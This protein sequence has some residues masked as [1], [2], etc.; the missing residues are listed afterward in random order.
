MLM[1]LLCAEVWQANDGHG[2]GTSAN[3]A[4]QQR[5]L[6]DQHVRNGTT[7]LQHGLDDLYLLLRSLRPQQDL[8]H[9][10]LAMSSDKYD[11][12]QSLR[13]QRGERRSYRV[14]DMHKGTEQGG[15]FFRYLQE[16]A[17]QVFDPEVLGVM[18]WHERG[19]CDSF[20]YVLRSSA[21]AYDL[22]IGK[23]RGYPARLFR[24]I[25][26][27]EDALA[28]AATAREHPCLL[29]AFS[30]D[31]VARYSTPQALQSMD[32]VKTLE[33]VANNLVCNIHA[34]E[35]AHTKNSKRA[36][37]RQ[38]RHLY[39]MLSTF[40]AIEKCAIAKLEMPLELA[41][42]RKV[43]LG[44][45]GPEAKRRRGSGGAWRA[46]VH[47]HAKGESLT[48]ER[49][50]DLARDYKALS[51][52]DKT[53][54]SEMGASATLAARSGATTFPILSARV[55]RERGSA[56]SSRSIAV[57]GDDNVEDARERVQ[58]L[59]EK[60]VRGDSSPLHSLGAH[61]VQAWNSRLKEQARDMITITLAGERQQASLA[62]NSIAESSA[63]L[64]AVNLQHRQ[65]LKDIR[66]I[67]WMAV[68]HVPNSSPTLF[69]ALNAQEAVAEAW[70][71]RSNIELQTSWRQAHLGLKQSSWDVP[72][73][74]SKNQQ[75]KASEPVFALWSLC[76]QVRASMSPAP[77]HTLEGILHKFAFGPTHQELDH[78][79]PN[80]SACVL[81][82]GPC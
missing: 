15:L 30:T 59:H 74:G 8:M 14:L 4:D 58:V 48:K 64:V 37:Q 16:L 56:K 51:A 80:D 66:R 71:G 47:V 77:P 7:W 26:R 29:D 54:Y 44:V 46:Y 45:P 5:E 33:C 82:S 6:L 34:V 40:S 65:R 38:T 42:K 17:S 21:T 43:A 67:N 36:R 52:A 23:C 22:I 49:M 19:L 75:I 32:S 70:S 18:V 57:A 20:R 55:G 28:I 31:H 25:D 72:D 60:A 62:A 81:V 3:D 78:A 50:S 61:W 35:S 79:R 1:L 76:V 39:N 41:L 13:E 69:A 27:P 10:L 63:K 24:L 9:A 73:A 53:P 11:A 2:I 12:E 68:G